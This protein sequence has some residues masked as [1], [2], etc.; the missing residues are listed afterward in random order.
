MK[1]FEQYDGLSTQELFQEGT[2][3]YEVLHSANEFKF[4]NSKAEARVN[5]HYVVDNKDELDKD[6]KP[7]GSIACYKVV[8]SSQVKLACICW[9]SRKAQPTS[10][11][12]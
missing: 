12:P 3:F 5:E 2:T 6:G 10:L 7:L 4:Y 1:G 9:V 8:T 11:P